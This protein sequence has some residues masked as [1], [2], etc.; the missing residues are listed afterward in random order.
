MVRIIGLVFLLA[1]S[2]FALSQV[3]PKNAELYLPMLE[4]ELIRLW[5][6]FIPKA[7]FAGQIEQE[8]CITLKHKKCWSPTAELKTSREYGFGLGQITVTERF[9]N[10]EDTKKLDKNLAGWKWENRFDPTY[11]IRALVV[12]D[13]HIYGKLPEPIE[14]KSAFMLAS[15]NGGLGGILKDRKLCEGTKGCNPNFWFNNVENTSFKSKTKP[16]GYGKSF[17]EIN[18]EYVY[19]IIFLR[20]A[21][22]YDLFD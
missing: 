3:I 20:S 6:K 14:D 17:F 22:Y 7:L 18:R 2:T 15:Y 10:F 8:T 21:K 4:M 9:N 16:K 1:F 5:P 13:K 11:Q 19:N 12:Y